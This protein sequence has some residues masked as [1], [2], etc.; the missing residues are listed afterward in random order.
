MKRLLLSWMFISVSVPAHSEYCQQFTE[1]AVEFRD[2]A[3]RIERGN[4]AKYGRDVKAYIAEYLL[5]DARSEWSGRSADEL[6]DYI[7]LQKAASEVAL[8][9]GGLGTIEFIE[10]VSIACRE[11]Y[12][13]LMNKAEEVESDARSGK[14]TS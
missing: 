14:S 7:Q 3:L 6:L 2:M 9:F 5:N 13:E 4:Q 10:K 11:A 8:N 12:L 1:A